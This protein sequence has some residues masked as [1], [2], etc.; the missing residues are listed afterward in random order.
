MV[1]ISMD[2]LGIALHLP[3][4]S[5]KLVSRATPVYKLGSHAILVSCRSALLTPHSHF[6]P[7]PRPHCPALCFP[8]ILLLSSLPL[9][10]PAHLAFPPP[11]PIHIPL[12]LLPLSVP[13]PFI[14]SLLSPLLSL[15]PA[16]LPLNFPLLQFQNSNM[17]L[18]RFCLFFSGD[19]TRQN[20]I[21]FSRFQSADCMGSC[22]S[23][24]R[25]AIYLAFVL[26]PSYLAQHLFD[27]R[28]QL[29]S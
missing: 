12:P 6:C 24:C 29:I 7:T 22:F 11:L 25:V 10:S 1:N 15:L 5:Q 8:A 9:P 2:N 13:S 4:M 18:L 21:L 19:K 3:G 23:S 27:F 20:L 16:P 28:Q 26:S 17:Y 14:F